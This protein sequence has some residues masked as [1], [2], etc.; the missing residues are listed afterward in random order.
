MA[1]SVTIKNKNLVVDDS[2]TI[3]RLAKNILSPLYEVVTVPGA[4]KMYKFLETHSVNLILLDVDMPEIDGYTALR[5]LKLSP[6]TQMIPVIFLSGETDEE[7]QKW[8]L[9]LGAEKFVEKPLNA[10]LL[11]KTVKEFLKF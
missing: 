7:M 6:N 11:L 3:L 2:L 8:S 9:S 1:E 4:E 10:G 5:R